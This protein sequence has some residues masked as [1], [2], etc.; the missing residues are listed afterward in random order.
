MPQATPWTPPLIAVAVDLAVFT[1]L[2]EQF[3]VLLIERGI[4]PDIGSLALPGGFLATASEDLS[5][6]AARE[7]AE[8]TGLDAAQV[9]LEQLATYGV[10]DRDPRQRV[11][12]VCYL[13]LVP[14]PLSPMAGG[15]ARNAAWRPVDD[16][17][18]AS[19]AFDHATILAEAVE[20]ARSKLEYTTVATSFCGPEFT[21]SELRRVY[22]I[23]WGRRLDPRNFQ[24][25]ILNI[26]GFVEATGKQTVRNGGRPALLYRAG[27]ARL[28]Q[29][30]ILRTRTDDSSPQ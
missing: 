13:A 3:A 16:I 18:P 28:V 29:P 27:P 15:D 19:L 10:P 11:V 17:E 1:V 4:E 22:E 20:R 8:E 2:D 6:A 21:M 30:P 5:A 9:H 14:G 26:P 7:L 12:T 24:R 23:V 25:K